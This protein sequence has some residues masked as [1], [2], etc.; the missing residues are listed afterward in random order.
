MNEPHP[1]VVAQQ[2]FVDALPLRSL[3]VEPCP[4][5]QALGRVLAQP[6]VAPF[7]T[8]P[9][10]RV[11]VEGFLVHSQDTQGASENEPITL[12]IVG[13]VMPGDRECPSF[14]RGEA[15]RVATGSIA[16]DGPY[17]VV[18]MFEANQHGE[19]FS[20][21][22]PFPPRFFI[23]ERGCDLARGVVAAPAGTLLDP[24]TI[25][26]IAALGIDRVDV[27]EKPRV[28]IYASGDEVVPYTDLPTP[29]QI[30]DSN[31]VML[32]AAV[33]AAGG[34]PTIAGIMRDDFEAFVSSLNGAIARSDMVV[35]SGG[36]AVGGRDFISDLVRSVGTLVVDGVP[37]RSGRPLIM[38]YAGIKPIVC[39]AGHPPEALRGFRLFG[40]AA[41]DRLLGRENA[42]PVD[43]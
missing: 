4:L 21:S 3:R 40:V 29:G 31:S 12:S 22:R 9:Y 38:G 28:T 35:I 39:V 18:R 41:I 14:G 33:T 36:T 13:E 32:A 23:E 43:A 8:P 19:R 6:V 1:L 17:A 10:H 26:T 16:P 37:M 2:K 24:A 27:T 25:G 20:I 5:D 15:L 7:D 42:L 11:I 30:R 34:V